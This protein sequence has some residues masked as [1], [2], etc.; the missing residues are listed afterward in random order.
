MIDPKLAELLERA[1]A[2]VMT[3]EEV[4]AQRKSWVKGE[5]MLKYPDMTEEQFEELYSGAVKRLNKDE[6]NS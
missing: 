1:K 3:D 4:A 5:M 2:Y 6:A